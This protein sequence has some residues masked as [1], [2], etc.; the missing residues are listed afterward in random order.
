MR[1]TVL[2]CCLLALLCSFGIVSSGYAGAYPTKPVRVMVPFNP[3][4]GTDQ[5]A[6]IIE[7]DFK[8]TFGQPL[9]FLYKPGADGSI[10]AT[11]LAG[12]R[13]DGYTIAVHTFPL[14]IMNIMSGKGQYSVDSFDYLAISSTDVV[15]LVT[16][17]D[18]PITSFDD[19]VAKAKANPGKLTVGA[20]ET[21]GPTHMAAMKLH[22]AGVPMNIVP[23]AGGAKGMAAVLGGHIDAYF[24][25][26][27]AAQSAASKL[28]YLAVA[29]PTRM[30][31]MPDVPTL[32]EKGYPINNMGA[33]IW[34][35]PKGLPVEAKERLV[36]GLK[37][38]YAREDVI[39]RQNAAGQPVDFREGGEL[40]VMIND[41][42]VEAAAMSELYK[43]NQQ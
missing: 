24:S 12:A 43:K 18:S 30:A 11:E 19:F 33:R 17:K 32:S 34:I 29:D 14:L 22:Q 1:Y 16:R 41:F 37:S 20:A 6:R 2:V 5:Q 21:L 8:D 39:A 9:T 13:P 25:L 28:T 31:D 4:G 42:A 40:A 26:K 36:E 3:G 35:A 10:G 7:K 27:G 15:V 38:I 23:M